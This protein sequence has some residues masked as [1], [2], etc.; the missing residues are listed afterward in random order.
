LIAPEPDDDSPLKTY[1]LVD[2]H[3]NGTAA[4]NIVIYFGVDDL[5]PGR[6]DA[7]SLSTD[8][9]HLTFQFWDGQYGPLVFDLR[10]VP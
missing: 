10:R 4:G 8:A 9:Q 1:E 6:L 2:L 7:V 5:V 3:Q